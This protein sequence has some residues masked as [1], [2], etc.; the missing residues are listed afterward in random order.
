[1]VKKGT[2][3]DA[4]RPQVMEGG[5]EAIMNEDEKEMEV[6]GAGTGRVIRWSRK[7]MSI[8]STG[9]PGKTTYGYG[10]DDRYW[11]MTL[12]APAENVETAA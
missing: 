7:A 9:E 12:T 8:T 3:V 10:P 6:K 4:V 11:I 2:E 5:A 1:M